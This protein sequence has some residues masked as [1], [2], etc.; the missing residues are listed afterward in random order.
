MINFS[1]TISPFLKKELDSLD[2]VRSTILVALLSPR[3]ETR[4]RWEV[5]V[6]RI[7]SAMQITHVDITEH[8]INTLLS[9]L[10]KKALN[11]T[12]K[13]IIAYK[14]AL[15][16]IRHDWNLTPE[17]VE[18]TTLTHLHK[19]IG[20]DLL[21]IPY[22]E[23]KNMVTFLQV[24]PEHPVIQAG[25]AFIIYYQMLGKNEEAKLHALLVAYVFM[26]KSGY[27]MRGMIN[28]EEYLL[29][30]AKSLFD[31]IDASLNSKNISAFLDYFTL[32]I[33]TQAE[34]AAKKLTQKDFDTSYPESFFT[35]TERQKS[36]ISLLDKP[37][38]RITNKSVQE[39]FHVSQITASR[40][41]AKLAT[42]GLLFSF[43]KGRSVYYTKS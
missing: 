40:E 26:Y 5:T 3:D 39:H 17:P 20:T 25:I 14:A 22:K 43:G 12:E 29:D 24:S 8:H 2:T 32:A 4:L 10:G 41:L 9:P 35:L 36:I 19:L 38:T 30:H 34:K 37:G 11:P 6:Q 31:L 18:P 23:L 13:S 27:E 21:R 7:I 28:L 42:L 16:Y 33:V 1:Y 15:D